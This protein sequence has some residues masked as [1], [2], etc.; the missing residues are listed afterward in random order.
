VYYPDRPAPL[1][2]VGEECIF[3]YPQQAQRLDNR[4]VVSDS[5]NDRLMVL[6]LRGEYRCHLQL[7][8]TVGAVAAHPRG[9]AVHD[10]LVYVADQFNHRVLVVTIAGDVCDIVRTMGPAFGPANA[11]RLSNPFNL[12]VST[13]GVFVQD[14]RTLSFFSHGG[15][16]VR[17]LITAGPQEARVWCHDLAA[18]NGEVFVLRVI[19]PNYVDVFSTA[20]VH[21]RRVGRACGEELHALAV[22]GRDLFLLAVRDEG[23]SMFMLTTHGTVLGALNLDAL[24]TPFPKP[25]SLYFTSMSF[26]ASGTRLYFTDHNHFCVYVL[27]NMPLQEQSC[28]RLPPAAES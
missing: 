10:G 2:A 9:V 7:Q 6:T 14:E 25:E 27:D 11:S 23:W 18:S 8:R 15:I 24:C 13:D 28:F 22:N 4:L 17:H 26:D 5:V 12:A 16:F 21:L 1:P 20:G 19:E 3:K